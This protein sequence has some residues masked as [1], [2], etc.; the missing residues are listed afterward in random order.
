M[1]TA[2]AIILA[3]GAAFL[4]GCATTTQKN[5]GMF[6]SKVAAMDVTAADIRQQTVTPLYSHKESVSG[7]SKVD[8]KLSITNLSADFSIPLWGTTWS[9]SASSIT[10]STPAAAAQVAAVASAK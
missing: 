6:L 1:K 2:F 8:G 7:I 3:A 9:F 5:A 4:S 10:A